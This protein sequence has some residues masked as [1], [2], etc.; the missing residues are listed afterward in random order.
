LPI[1][2]LLRCGEVVDQVVV[3]TLLTCFSSAVSRTDMNGDLSLSLALKNECKPAVINSI[4]MQF[5]QAAGILDGE[6]HSPLFLAFQHNADDRTI[7]G[8][9]NHSPEVSTTR[10][11]TIWFL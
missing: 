10:P 3:K 4:M 6:G 2:L 11:L 1:H 5:P 9:L 7:L 8:L